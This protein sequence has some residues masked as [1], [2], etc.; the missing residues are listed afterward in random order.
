[1]ALSPTEEFTE[2][3]TAED[4]ATPDTADQYVAG[5]YKDVPHTLNVDGLNLTDL[6]RIITPLKVENVQ[7]AGSLK[8]CNQR[9]FEVT[10][11]LRRFFTDPTRRE[12]LKDQSEDTELC[13]FLRGLIAF[14]RRVAVEEDP[15]LSFYQR[16]WEYER[17]EAEM[18]CSSLARPAGFSQMAL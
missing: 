14:Y 12:W 6:M 1:M 13:A 5:P 3:F 7:L 11:V 15:T 18:R 4:Y 8:W 16:I 2:E 17:G 9:L 10:R